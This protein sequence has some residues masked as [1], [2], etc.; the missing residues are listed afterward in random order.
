MRLTINNKEEEFT[1]NTLTELLNIHG[2][3]DKTGVAVAVNEIVIPRQEW[4][5]HVLEEGDEI[6]IIVPARGG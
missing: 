6:L 1:G 5:F 3:G 2:I 4:Q